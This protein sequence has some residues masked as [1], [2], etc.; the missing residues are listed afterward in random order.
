MRQPDLAH[1]AVQSQ[2]PA[3]I[4]AHWQSSNRSFYRF[5]CCSSAKQNR[6]LWWDALEPVSISASAKRRLEAIG[7][8]AAQV[9]MS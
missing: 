9:R 2:V 4:V 8:E 7:M 5:V 6:N 3:E 1:Q